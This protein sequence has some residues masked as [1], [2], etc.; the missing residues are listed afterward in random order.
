MAPASVLTRS[1]PSSDGERAR[2]SA[3]RAGPEQ[4]AVGRTVGAT[5]PLPPA[6]N[7]GTGQDQRL[8]VFARSAPDPARV[9]VGFEL[10]ELQPS[11]PPLQSW[12]PDRCVSPEPSADCA[13]RRAVWAIGRNFSRSNAERCVRFWTNR[14]LPRAIRCRPS[15]VISCSRVA[16]SISASSPV[17][18]TASRDHQILR[19]DG[20]GPAR[21]GQYRQAVCQSRRS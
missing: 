21:T 4:L 20:V 17:R 10:R 5:W 8:D 9:H 7:V 6:N 3:D 1:C 19:D 15:N 13:A 16:G 14:S 18:I 2:T 12:P 11:R